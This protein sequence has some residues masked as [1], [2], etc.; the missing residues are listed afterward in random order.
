[1]N[2]DLA[3]R[4]Q[5]ALPK[6]TL[7][8]FR[9]KLLWEG[10]CH[11]H[12]RLTNHGEDAATVAAGAAFDADFVGPV[13]GARHQRARAGRAPAA[14]GGQPEVVLPYRSG[15]D[16]R[17]AA[18]ACAST[19][20]R[21]PI[22]AHAPIR[23][24]GSTPATGTHLYCPMSC[25]C[26][27][28]PAPRALLGAALPRT[29]RAGARARVR[30][31][32]STSNPLVNLWLDRSVSD[33]AMLTTELPTGPYPYAG[34]PWYSTPFGRDGIITA[35][36]YL[37]IDPALARGVLASSRQPGHRGRPARD[38]EPGKI[39]HEARAS[40][41]ARTREIPFGRYYGTVDATP[42]F[43]VLAAAY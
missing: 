32:L 36:E 9:A 21:A 12:I 31:R 34:V 39:L 5:G 10:A 6:G 28:E 22:D 7:H 1:M 3:A 29:M 37:W 11:E 30:R 38:A 43:V 19:R 23:D 35:L 16:G 17:R 20:R 25:E 14:G 40:E 41:M 27:G 26:E 33:L 18:R 4:R 8:I 42:L 2:P 24:R 13:R 15:L